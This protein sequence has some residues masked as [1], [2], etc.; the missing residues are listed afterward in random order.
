MPQSL[1][2]QLDQL[3]LTSL[4]TGTS[5]EDI[6]QLLMSKAEMLS[7][8]GPIVQAVI[9]ARTTRGGKDL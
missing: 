3:V 2:D 6:F 4:R 9:D 5:M 7:Q 1:S 8:A